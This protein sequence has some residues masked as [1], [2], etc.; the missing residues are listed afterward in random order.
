MLP[1]APEGRRYVLTAAWLGVLTLLFGFTTA[2]VLLVLLA[3][4]L[5]LVFRDVLRRVPAQALGVVAPADGEVQSVQEAPNP[6]TGQPAKRIVIQ[7]RLWG[8]YNLH[9]PQAAKVIQRV[10]PGK[11][12]DAPAD[13]QLAGQLGLAF[14][15]AEGNAFALAVDV[16][17]WR[18][19]VRV[20]AITGNF[21]GRGQRLGFAGFGTRVTLWLPLKS[22]VSARPG[23][24]LR[25]GSDLLGQLPA[26][27]PDPK[28]KVGR[29]GQTRA[30]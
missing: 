27:K 24:R 1:I 26:G 22:Q 13:A 30:E 7:Q 16:D 4:L 9:A 20:G 14:E 6:F 28:T 3:I 29:A 21:I 5:I 2:G 25:A 18:R 10:W 8:E 17:H 11:Q 23:Q 15:T 19:F 12:T